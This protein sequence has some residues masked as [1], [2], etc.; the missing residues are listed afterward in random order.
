MVGLQGFI[1]VRAASDGK[2]DA[3]LEPLRRACERALQR[4]PEGYT[5]GMALALALF[6][7]VVTAGCC[8]IAYRSWRRSHILALEMIQLRDRLARAERSQAASE[9]RARVDDEVTRERSSESDDARLRDM[10]G[11]LADLHGQLSDA[12]EANESLAARAESL[13]QRD[14]DDEHDPLDVRDLIRQGL[15][16]QGYRRVRVIEV[17]ADD[18]VLVEAERGGITAKGTAWVDLDGQVV[19]RSQ[20][21][22]RAFP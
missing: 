13:E 7:L 17:T 6:A 1:P 4:V 16:R 22:L 9:R 15:R 3:N 19:L 5:A 12:V 21:T 20:S 2:N 8:V 14:G 18:R 11:R 10:E